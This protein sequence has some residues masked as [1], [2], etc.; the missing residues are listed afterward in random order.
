VQA[1][2]L[3]EEG[4]MLDR[5]LQARLLGTLVLTPLGLGACSDTVSVET[6]D[7]V[8]SA[9]VLSVNGDLVDYAVMKQGMGRLARRVALALQDEALRQRVFDALQASEI[10]E[11]KLH[12]RTLLGDEDVGLRQSIRVASGLQEGTLDASLDSLVDL[13]F[14]V[15]VPEHRA[16]WTGDE[17]VIVVSFPDDDGSQPVGFDLQGRAV[18]S[19]SSRLGSSRTSSARAPTCPRPIIGT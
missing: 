10:P 7:P 12:F 2:L 11:N 16:A 3:A 18:P 17:N 13:E 9:P 19:R 1:T 5:R 14:Y 15:P 4:K 8:P 6:S